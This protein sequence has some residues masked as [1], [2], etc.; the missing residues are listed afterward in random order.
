MIF[1]HYLGVGLSTPLVLFFAM[2]LYLEV[3]NGDKSM[4]NVRQVFSSLTAIG[5][6]V[7]Y[8]VWNL[9]GIIQS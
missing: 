2:C 6:I 8:L 7:I 5:V 9:K 3:K 4:N 1:L